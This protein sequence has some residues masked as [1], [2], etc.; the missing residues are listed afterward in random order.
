[1]NS[2]DEDIPTLNLTFL[3]AGAAWD[4]APCF[5]F[6]GAAATAGAC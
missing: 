4:V 1:M 6:E 3:G 2:K 5:D